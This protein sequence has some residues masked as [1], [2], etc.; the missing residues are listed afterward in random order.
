MSEDPG[1]PRPATAPAVRSAA[2]GSWPGHDVADAIKIAFETLDLPG[3]PELPARGPHAALV[4]RGAALLTGLGVDLRPAGWRL[5]DSSGRDHRRAVAT[6]RSDL[7]QLEEQAQGYA[8]DL[9]IA[10]AGPWTLAATLEHPRGDKVLADPGARRDVGQSLTEGVA[11]LVA[12]L[13]RRLPDLQLVIQLDEPSLPSVLAGDVTTASGLSRHG[14]VD[15]P[16]VSEAYSQLVERLAE[17][18]VPVW[19]HSCAADVPAG[20]LFRAG[21]SGV[22]VDLDQTRP[23]Q[24]DEIGTAMEGGLVLGA[25]AVAAGSEPGPDQVAARTLAALRAL[26]LDPSITGRTL[27]TPAC[28]LASVT[29]AQAVRTLRTL[30]TAARIVTEQ[31]AA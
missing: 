24:W 3:L 26:D 12:D 25:G 16:E 27:L 29:V 8:G 15:V 28:G 10:V 9:K 6:L 20:L 11:D 30:R 7:D 2:I 19:V 21:V 31:L 14:A 13:Q 18:A 23:A 5:A 17:A 22:L 4:G 1:G